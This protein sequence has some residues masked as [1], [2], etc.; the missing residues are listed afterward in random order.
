MATGSGF[1]E[2]VRAQMEDQILA[3]LERKGARLRQEAE[4]A[5]AERAAA[6]SQKDKRAA[7][8]REKE[9][10]EQLTAHRA[11]EEKFAARV[12]ARL[13]A[14]RGEYGITDDLNETPD[15]SA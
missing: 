10:E 13:L 14:E 7:S 4:R 1:L 2:T 11:V 6:A 15:G 3:G 12:K 5:S 8:I 9:V